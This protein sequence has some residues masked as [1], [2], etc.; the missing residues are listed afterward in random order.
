MQ[1]TQTLS[2]GLRRE[3]KVVVSAKDIEEKFNDRLVEL[4]RTVRLPGFR[5]G[6]VPS[7]ILKQRFGQGLMGEILEQAVNDSAA[8]AMA[9][10]G[11]QPVMQPK[12][13]VTAFEDGKDL[14]YT[15]ALE[16]MPEIKPMDFSALELERLTAEVDAAAVDKA[17]RDL[18]AQYRRS[19]PIAKPRESKSGDVLV[20]DFTGTIDGKPFAGGSGS[21]HHLELGSSE[22]VAGFE[23]QLIG[24]EAGAEK[25][26]SVTFPEDYPNE[27]LAGKPAVFQVK[28]KEIRERRPVE[29]D[30]E[31]AQSVGVESLAKLR[32]AVRGRLTRD[33]A[34]WSRNRLKRMLLDKLAEAHDFNVPPGLTEREFEEIW[35]QR[36]EQQAQGLTDPEEEGKAEDEIKEDYRRIAERRVRL[37]LLLNEVG[38]LNNI[39][40]TDEEVAQLIAAEAQRHPGHERKV[41]EMFRDNPDRAAA[42]KAPILEEKVVDFIL[43]IANVSERTVSI[44]ELMRDPDTDADAAANVGARKKTG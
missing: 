27:A 7:K 5:P 18:S 23:G 44:D 21:D 13:E 10:Q 2:E 37:G 30:D 4:G 14:E 36:E 22:F 1:V 39:Q 12:I 15:M 41:Y 33:Y 43:E 11:L 6:K 29:L 31:F 38:R 19:A 34:S 28:V 25:E 20:I 42:L 8:Q 16:L 32:D 35:R 24:L 17:L 9:E 3:F 40:V 26:I